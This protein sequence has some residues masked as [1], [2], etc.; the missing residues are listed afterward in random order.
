MTLLKMECER[1]KIENEK[2]IKGGHKEG[3]NYFVYSLSLGK[4]IELCNFNKTLI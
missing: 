4:I 1:T 2:Q 3:V